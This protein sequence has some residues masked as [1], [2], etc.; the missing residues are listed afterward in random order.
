MKIY[1]VV[2]ES[3]VTGKKINQQPLTGVEDIYYMAGYTSFIGKRGFH[4]FNNV[5]IDKNIDGKYFYL[6]AEDA[7][8][9]ASKL[10]RGFHQL[11]FDT[12]SLL[13]YD[14]PTD[15]VIKNIGYG[16]YTEDIYPWYLVETFIEKDFLGNKTITTAQLSDEEKF[17]YLEI[18]LAETLRRIQELGYS[19]FNDCLFYKKLFDTKDLNS[20]INNFKASVGVIKD[21]N[22][23]QAFMEENGEL[24]KTKYITKKIVPVN[25]DY[26]YHELGDYE[27][28]S[29][30]Y[31]TGYDLNCDFSQEQSDFKD[32]LLKAIKKKSGQEKIK[33]LLKEKSI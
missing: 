2:P 25:S 5:D 29:D 24:I 28:I 33:R 20:I 12:C 8:E 17:D 1:R 9:E 11:S 22:F 21:S 19:S 31:K 30:Y 6:F 7:I 26:L 18:S 15:I 14:I 3:L 23:Y 16:D 4:E 10:L 13:E 32:E 27:K